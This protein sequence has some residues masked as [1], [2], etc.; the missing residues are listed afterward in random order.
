VKP[1][2]GRKTCLSRTLNNNR[3]KTS[4]TNNSSPLSKQ[5]PEIK[6]DGNAVLHQKAARAA[7][8]HAELNALLDKQAQRRV[9][10][11]NRPFGS[12]FID[13]V[14]K[15]KAELINI[16]AAFTCVLLAYQISNIRKGAR[17]LLDEAGEKELRME[18]L[19]QMLRLL[20]NEE[21][22]DRVAKAY[23]EKLEKSKLMEL[24]KSGKRWLARGGDLKNNDTSRLE[25]NQ[26]VLKEVLDN[27][28]R[29]VIGDI[30]MTDYE[31]EEK[32]L[33]ALQ[34]GMGILN[35]NDVNDNTDSSLGDLE[36]VFVEI[37]QGSEADATSTKTA[38]RKGFI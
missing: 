20:S 34:K 38:K 28:L 22:S 35:S 26:T 15:S 8:L 36:Q 17:K 16:F 2:I 23:E 24:E 3:W 12:G 6:I 14:K 33:N 30:A 7:E 31:L 29:G 13:F 11:A 9:D 18:K 32:K 37:Q 4:T 19:K 27:E 25:K 21:F 10:E 5:A 1:S